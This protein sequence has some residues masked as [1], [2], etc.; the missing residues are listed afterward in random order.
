MQLNLHN[1]GTNVKVTKQ[2]VHDT[3]TVTFI[4]HYRQKCH[5]SEFQIQ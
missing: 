1:K 3:S 2:M 5:K 4:E